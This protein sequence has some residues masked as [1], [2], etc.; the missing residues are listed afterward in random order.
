LLRIRLF[1]ILLPGALLVFVVLFI[2]GLKPRSGVHTR[3]A[4][5]APNSRRLEGVSAVELSA[6]RRTLAMIA[7]LVEHQGEDRVHLERI[8]RLEVDRKGRGP[9]ILRSE[10][11]QIEGPPGER[12]MRFDEEVTVYDP[13]EQLTA[14]IPALEVDEADGE[15]RS[16]AQV[17]LEGRRLAGQAAS[18]IY[19]LADRPTEL[20][21]PRLQGQD[22]S[23][24]RART[25]WL[26]DGLDDVE[27]L[28]EVHLARGE[29]RLEGRS[30]RWRRS[31]DDRLRDAVAQGRV[32][33]RVLAEPAA[34]LDF[35]CERAQVEWD[36]TG[37]PQRVHLEGETSLRETER[38][39]A[40]QSVEAARLPAEQGGWSI[41]AEGAVHLQGR[42]GQEP[43]L[44]RADRL[45]ALVDLAHSLRSARATG[46]V[47]FDGS[48]TR[49]ESNEAEFSAEGPGEIRLTGAGHR[50]ARL[51]REQTRIAADRIT[52]DPSGVELQAEGRVEATLL[53]APDAPRSTAGAGLFLAGDAVHFVSE[54]LVGQRSGEQ[55]RFT[56]AV[57]AWQGERNLSAER[58]SLDRRTR[59]LLAEDDVSTR[60]PRGG[61]AG[62]ASESDYVQIGADRLDYRDA[63][64]LGEFTGGVRLRLLEGWM[65]A[66]RMV[67]RLAQAGGGIDEIRSFDTVRFEFRRPVAGGPPELT[68]GATDRLRYSPLERTVW[69]YGDSSP[70][71]VR[72]SGDS[73]GTTTG[74][75]LRYQLDS[76]A[77]EVDSGEQGPA[78]ILTS[79]KGSG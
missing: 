72:R 53:P 6:G 40:A 1:R 75:V 17:T 68:S 65:E 49:A 33:G 70:A 13:E 8:R 32:S 74:R 20:R 43:G 55:L 41:R 36:A 42:F 39:L 45:E 76:G 54:R 30:V 69:L 2:A 60:V 67:I 31:P 7:D 73:A 26:H 5:S 56:G 29:E 25:A 9:L 16:L 12:T 63:E 34:P 51:A 10:L 14:R 35:L 62:V 21:E 19:G 22:G 27:L 59:V 71:T 38:G 24:L 48:Q 18:M 28:G 79:G 15:A 58:V 61:V 46:H 44:L 47:S 37:Q 3:P 77:L 50:K 66:E 23:T 64:R 57:R 11:G 4:T 78:R 52:T